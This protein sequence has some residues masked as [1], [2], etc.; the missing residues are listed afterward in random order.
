MGSDTHGW[1]ADAVKV[2]ND[3]VNQIRSS[4]KAYE[5]GMRPFELLNIGRNRGAIVPFGT[6]SVGGQFVSQPSYGGN[7]TGGIMFTKAGQDYVQDLLNKRQKQYAEMYGT[8]Q[9]R[10]SAMGEEVDDGDRVLAVVTP[11]LNT[12]L[13]DLRTFTLKTD[14]YAKFWATMLTSLPLLGSNSRDKIREIISNL[15]RALDEAYTGAEKRENDGVL[16]RKEAEN[17]ES[18]NVRIQ[19]A[20]EVM[21]AYIGDTPDGSPA[22][23]DSTSASQRATIVEDLNRRLGET[24]KPAYLRAARSTIADQLAAAAAAG[25]PI[26]VGD[27]PPEDIDRTLDDVDAAAAAA[28]VA[29][30][31]I[32]P[33]VLGMGRGRGRGRGGARGGAQSR[34]VRLPSTAANLPAEDTRHNFQRKITQIAP[35]HRLLNAKNERD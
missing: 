10:D 17:L 21:N 19:R 14:S 15:E 33:P 8:T 35:H 2:A 11:V 23:I 12:L 20:I 30:Q 22:P 18:L 13:D 29:A 32:P 27:I 1:Y 4:Q 16:T 25:I 26:V 5:R 7:L 9:Q 3:R 34:Q 6:G 31:P 28:A 24:L